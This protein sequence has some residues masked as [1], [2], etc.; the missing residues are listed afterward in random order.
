MSL[1]KKVALLIFRLFLAAGFVWSVLCFLAIKPAAAQ[2]SAA[3]PQPQVANVSAGQ[4]TIIQGEKITG[5]SISFSQVRI[6]IAHNFYALAEVKLGANG[7]QDFSVETTGLKAGRYDLTLITDYFRGLESSPLDLKLTVQEK[8]IGPTLFDPVLNQETN[9]RQPWIVGVVPNDSRVEIFIDDQLTGDLVITN[10]PNGTASFRYQPPKLADGYHVASARS[11]Q[12]ANGPS[13]FSNQIIFLVKQQVVVKRAPGLKTD[14]EKFIPPVPAPTLLEPATGLVT[15]ETK[16]I[17]KGLMHNNHW[18][19]IYLDNELAGEFM[20][21]PHTSGVTNFSWQATQDLKPGVHQV[22]ARAINPRGQISA[23]SMTL[24]WLV[25]PAA[26]IFVSQ[27]T[28]RVSSA[29][30]SVGPPEENPE[31]KVLNEAEQNVLGIKE[32]NFKWYLAGALIVL[33]GI[34]LW[35]FFRFKK[36]DN[37]QINP[38]NN[39]DITPDTP[40]DLPPIN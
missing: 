34:L 8:I 30:D 19:E 13:N 31:I 22:Y 9:F 36:K 27:S 6:F 33:I 20:P 38:G 28:G 26:P 2:I 40:E 15:S 23:H 32:T 25:L 35:Q 12:Q 11:Y 1:T 10:S 21:E 29:A 5:Q 17:I 14:Q 7:W 18:V 39:T 16:P 4:I 24:K 37:E 3:I